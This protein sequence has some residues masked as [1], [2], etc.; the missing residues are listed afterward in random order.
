VPIKRLIYA[1]FGS[2]LFATVSFA[3]LTAELPS[4]PHVA[5]VLSGGGARGLS[6][7][8][9]LEIL[10]SAKVPI[11]LVVGTSMGSV[12]GG[13]YAAGY[14][15]KELEKIATETN[16]TDILS[17][18]DDSRRNERL[19]GQKDERSTL[20][21][22]RF[23]GFLH[24]VLPQAISSGQ[25]LTMLLNGLILSSPYGTQENFLTGLKVPFISLA[26]D[27][28]TGTRKL[29]TQGDLTAAKRSFGIGMNLILRGM[30]PIKLLR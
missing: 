25:R 30:S 21:S 1:V 10:D 17:F 3:Q 16:W 13:L 9:V 29:I 4:K 2:C 19:P 7:I 22:L 24:P 23:N 20:L 12:V 14:T 6:H 8:G 5:L 28:V 11:D 26:T 15:P 18:S 27:I